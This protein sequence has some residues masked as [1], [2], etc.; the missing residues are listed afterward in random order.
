MTALLLSQLAAGIKGRLI[1]ADLPI[2]ALRRL[3][4]AS[5]SDLGVVLRPQDL[6]ALPT[7]QASA[8]LLSLKDAAENLDRAPCSVLVV[9]HPSAA[10][11]FI[12]RALNATTKQAPE[13]RGQGC[14]IHATAIVE[15][16]V[17]MGDD[18]VID[19]FAVIKK[20]SRLGHRVHIGPHCVIGAE[21]FAFYDAEAGPRR[22]PHFYGAQLGDDVALGA[23]VCVDAGFLAATQIGCRSKIDN[24]VQIAHD[25]TLGTDCLIAAQ[26]GIAGHARI[27]SGV[28]IG[29][30]VGVA[31]FVRIGDGA[32][33]SAQA[34]IARDFEAF[35]VASGTPAMPH[36]DYLRA[37]AVVKRM[38][39]PLNFK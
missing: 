23:H 16:G 34:G 37:N 5:H 11:D 26:S 12:L 39:R 8:L 6:R 27:G 20:G 30:Q 7:T 10:L 29:G 4:E 13:S 31:P 35:S 9:D 33:L 22:L 14:R 25:V 1:G 28:T 21:G 19:A 32:R 18:S 3:D 2:S 15:D 17:V 24:F 36:M 38:S